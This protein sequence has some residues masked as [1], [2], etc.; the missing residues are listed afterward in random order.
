MLK[1]TILSGLIWLAFASFGSDSMA[2]CSADTDVLSDCGDGFR[3]AAQ[4]VFKKSDE[5]E[6]TTTVKEAVEECW[7]CAQDSVS[8]SI[9]NFGRDTPIYNG[10]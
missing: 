3:E 9:N 7:K 2:G 10:N 8:D 5:A 4:D 1:M 6:R